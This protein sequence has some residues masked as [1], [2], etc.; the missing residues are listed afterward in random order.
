[1]QDKQDRVASGPPANPPPKVASAWDLWQ[2]LCKGERGC[3]GLGLIPKV[4]P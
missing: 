3:E 2:L 4:G 1:M